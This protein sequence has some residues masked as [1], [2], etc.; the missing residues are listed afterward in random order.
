M[1]DNR[2]SIRKIDD[3]IKENQK[4]REHKFTYNIGEKNLTIIVKTYLDSSDMFACSSQIASATFIDG[5]YTPSVFEA[6]C[7]MNFILFYTNIKIE[8]GVER[9]LQLKYLCGA[10]DEWMDV[11]N[12][13]QWENIKYSALKEIE[14]R[15]NT[16][17]S[18]QEY[19]ASELMSKLENITVALDAVTKN[20]S[21]VDPDTINEAVRKMA[22][23]DESTIIKSL[24]N[25]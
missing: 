18:W 15:C 6:S 9:I 14:Y 17:N 24:R 20:F 16:L 3:F 1:A 7:L 4:E 25:D 2:I 11:I 22:S 5:Q 13:E 12:K 8:A 10:I 19:Q 23:V 21:N